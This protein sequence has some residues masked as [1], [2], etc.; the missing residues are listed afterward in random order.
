MF[1]KGLIASFPIAIGYIPVAI[2][3]GV[4]ALAL[5]F[6][7]IEAILASA[8]IFAGASQFALI[9]LINHSFV[10]AVTI[11]II[12]NLR[13]VVYGCIV[14]QRFEISKP[15]VTAFGL[16]DEVFATSLNAP[17]NERFVWGLEF[18][19]YVSW[20]LG[21]AIGI[22]CGAVLLSNKIL[23]PSLVFSLT[24]LFLILLIPNL[25]GHKL[26]ALV[27]G[28]IA[29]MFH[30]LGHTSTGILLAG[31]LSPIVVQRVRR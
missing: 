6:N 20:I 13:H 18:G 3:F 16:T 17:N 26:S 15:F 5:G 8:L 10:D 23:A 22:L 29:L 24:A 25:N 12:L 9:S 11:P 27:G 2:T 1:K 31:I 14:S 7:E 19:A 28:V 4:S 30:S 21:T